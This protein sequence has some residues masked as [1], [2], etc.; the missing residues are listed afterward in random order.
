MQCSANPFHLC[1]H[2][3]QL[4]FTTLVQCGWDELL[5][6][7]EKS[8]WWVQ[9]RWEQAK[10]WKKNQFENINWQ[11]SER[12]KKWGSKYNLC[13]QW[14]GRQTTM[15]IL[16]KA[17]AINLSWDWLAASDKL[18]LY[19]S[20][21]LNIGF[22][23]KESHQLSVYCCCPSSKATEQQHS[24]LTNRLDWHICFSFHFSVQWLP[25]WANSSFSHLQNVWNVIL[26]TIIIFTLR[27]MS[28]L[29]LT[30][31]PIRSVSIWKC[32]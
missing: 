5:W 10:L 18:Q 29:Y 32:C 23:S 7:K 25:G 19:V 6:T 15:Y 31:F 30:A 14:I 21:C 24:K 20:E 11:R 28:R 16:F 17:K 1:V 26:R 8:V 12:R 9:V 27:E 13:C 4:V 3:L 22:C 2:P